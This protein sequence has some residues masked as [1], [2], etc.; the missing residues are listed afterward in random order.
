MFSRK[1]IAV[2]VLLVFITAGCSSGHGATDSQ[3]HPPASGHSVSSSLVKNSD[4]DTLLNICTGFHLI[5]YDGP[6]FD[7][8][9]IKKASD[10]SPTGMYIY[11]VNTDK[12]LE[13]F[14][15]KTE[16]KYKIPVVYVQDYINKHFDG[17]TFEPEKI[18][19]NVYDSK[20]KALIAEALPSPDTGFPTISKKEAL[21]TDTM[22]IS[23]KY[24]DRYDNQESDNVLYTETI[25]LRIVGNDYKFVSSAIIK[26]TQNTLG[27]NPTLLTAEELNYFNGNEFFNG[28]YINIRN[29]FLSSLYDTPE[30]IDL[31][32]LFYCGSGQWVF[33]TEA[34]LADLIAQSGRSR[35]P[36]CGCDKIRRI[37]M[38]AVLKKYTGLTLADTDKTGLSKFTYLKKY[39]AYYHFH[40]DTNYRMETNFSSGEREGDIIRLFYN[41]TFMADGNKVLTLRK[42]ND[43]YLFI[44]NQTDLST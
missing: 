4:N 34:E 23:V 42:T 5:R 12:N 7:M 44:S 30:K 11:V 15:D 38:D 43:G 1:S 8:K 18:L 35:A 40:G 2:G 41:D 13:Q 19:Y 20:A 6:N 25:T 26:P 21:G 28:E 36:D 24:Y 10:I 29:Q 22:K 39:D 14:Y 32:A 27:P 31:Y 37:D 17:Y 3:S 9:T 33:P 16:R